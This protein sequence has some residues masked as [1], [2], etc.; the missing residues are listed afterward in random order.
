MW[1]NQLSG[2]RGHA[3]N[4]ADTPYK[5]QKNPVNKS[6]CVSVGT[7][8]IG[9]L[10]CME[11]VGEGTLETCGQLGLDETGRTKHRNYLIIEALCRPDFSRNIICK[12]FISKPTFLAYCFS[13]VWEAGTTGQR[14]GFF[15]TNS[16]AFSFVWTCESIVF[17][18]LR[19]INLR[20]CRE[21]GIE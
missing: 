9:F 2:K 1:G 14:A 11:S 5:K 4:R 13:S 3:F 8:R 20:K 16:N 19:V 17:A 7:S 12:T 15:Q 21:R 6:Q 18:H 10:G